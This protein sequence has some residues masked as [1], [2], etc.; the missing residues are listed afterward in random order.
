MSDTI[1]AAIFGLGGLVF[2]VGIT[3][4]NRSRIERGRLR[5]ESFYKRLQAHQQAFGQCQ[6]LGIAVTD[7]DLERIKNI[8]SEGLKWWNYSCLYLDT[9]SRS[10]FLTLFHIAQKYADGVENARRIIW[11]QLTKTEKSILRGIR[12]EY[13]PEGCPLPEELQAV[14]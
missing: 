4:F 1:I 2:G 3:E 14:I 9:V 8:A 5:K 13:L 7:I 12:M 10:E 11:E 6:D